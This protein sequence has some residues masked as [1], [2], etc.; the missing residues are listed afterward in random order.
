M[1][2]TL[3]A[4]I[5][6]EVDAFVAEVWARRPEVFRYEAGPRLLPEAAAWEMVECGLLVAP[7]FSMLRETGGGATAQGITMTREVLGRALP[8]YADPAA[9]RAKYAAGRVITL[10]QPEHWHVG[11]RGVL[12]ALRADLRGGANSVIFLSPPGATAS[13]EHTAEQHVLHFQLDGESC[14][15]LPPGPAI[16]LVPGDV[17]YLPGG[18]EHHSEAGPGGSFHLAV[19]IEQPTSRELAD[20]IVAEFLDSPGATEIAGNH[21]FLTLAEKTAWLRTELGK[22]LSD[23]DLAALVDQA[24]RNRQRGGHI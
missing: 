19:T 16:T 11:I 15:T 20:L 14:W 1:T 5:V 3:L 9:V 10:N 24:V 18:Q 17:L 21:H 7:Y 22:T 8:A 6:G 4:D 12:D 13:S 2:T 23:L